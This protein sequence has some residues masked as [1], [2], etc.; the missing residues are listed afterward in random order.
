[1]YI[2]YFFLAISYSLLVERADHWPYCW[3]N[4][5]ALWR[6]SDMVPSMRTSIKSFHKTFSITKLRGI[7]RSQHRLTL[8]IRN[9]S[10][11]KHCARITVYSESVAINAIWRLVSEI[12]G[13]KISLPVYSSKLLVAADFT[14]KFFLSTWRRAAIPSLDKHLRVDE[15]FISRYLQNCGFQTRSAKIALDKKISL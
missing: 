11:S 3:P 4:V 5:R 7:P 1:M 15:F 2:F 6:S 9:W 10:R 13:A 14:I 8:V 12:S